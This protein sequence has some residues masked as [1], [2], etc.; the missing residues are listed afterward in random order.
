MAKKRRKPKADADLRTVIIKALIGSAV[1]TAVFFALTALIAF[2]CLK[3]D[4][5]PESYKFFMLAVGAV[6]GFLCGYSA[7][8]PVRKKGIIIGILS[9]M[10]MYFVISCV[11]MLVSHGG[12]G[13]VGWI[14]CAVLLAA[15]G[16]G[17][18]I[19]VS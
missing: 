2:I 13:A 14:L 15:G 11:S 8:K 3:N 18:I 16:T 6:S 9:T 19:A 1:G 7:V 12:I 4:S 5:A 10:P 17:G